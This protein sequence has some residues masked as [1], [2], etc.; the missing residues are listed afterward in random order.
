MYQTPY[1]TTTLSN[2]NVIEIKNKIEQDL[3][4]GEMSYK[5]LLDMYRYANENILTINDSENTMHIPL[6]SQPLIVNTKPTTNGSEYNA[7][8]IDCRGFTSVS[9]VGVTS[10]KKPAQYKNHLIGAVL[11]NY[12]YLD[13]NVSMYNFCKFPTKVFSSWITGTLASKLNLDALSQVRTSAIVAYYFICLFHN[14]PEYGE[15]NLLDEDELYSI[16]IKVGYAT[17][18]KSH[19]AMEMIRNIPT[20]SNINDLSS[21]LKQ[22]GGSDRYKQLNITLIYM[23]LGRFGMNGLTPETVIASIEYPPLFM[24]M[25]YIAATERGY[26]KSNIGNVVHNLRNMTD[27]K[28]FIQE[29]GTILQGD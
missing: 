17:G 10:V 15:N 24:T 2:Y 14:Y 28:T 27:V 20:M 3:V 23:L 29:V 19:D 12:W 6:F 11:S 4:I 13:G 16:G 18:L 22:H 1:E 5:P 21:A 7:M 26:N 25:V 8:I 9:R